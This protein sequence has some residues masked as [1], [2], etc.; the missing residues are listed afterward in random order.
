L[1]STKRPVSRKQL[2]S[3]GF[4]LAGGFLV[5]GLWPMVFRHQDPRVWALVI[6][7]I[8]ALGGLFVPSALRQ[9][10][11][12]WMALG[13][14][15]GWVNSKILLTIIFYGLVAP[16]RLLVTAMGRDPMQRKFDQA[17]STYRVSRKPR[18]ISHMKHQF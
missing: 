16:T 6:T 7:G 8:F 3:F 2:R 14:G 11:R 4:I 12:I 18:P 9:P 1:F 10:Y 17:R 13:L 15:L 5:I